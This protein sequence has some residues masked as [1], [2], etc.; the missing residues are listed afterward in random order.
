[1]PHAMRR[2][3]EN[4]SVGFGSSLRHHAHILLWP[5]VQGHRQ[6]WSFP[7]IMRAEVAR[8]GG[9]V[10]LANHAVYDC[11]DDAVTEALGHGLPLVGAE[12]AL[13]AAAL[14]R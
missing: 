12:H 3:T 11:G 7:W 8:R 6:V 1:M 9:G 2:S 4:G 10:E 14:A 13:E 5:H